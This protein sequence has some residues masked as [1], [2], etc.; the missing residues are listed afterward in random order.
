[1]TAEQEKR[2]KELKRELECWREEVLALNSVLAWEKHWY[3]WLLIGISTTLFTFLW[4]LDMSVLSTVAVACLVVT[5][6]DYLGPIARTSICARDSWSGAKERQ[7]EDVCRALARTEHQV[8]SC[9][10]SRQSIKAAWPHLYVVVEVIGLA[11]LA[12]IGYTVNNMFLSYLLVTTALM[13]PGLKHSGF[14]C[15]LSSDVKT[16]FSSSIKMKKN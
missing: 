11:C 12:Y 9:W 5:A 14:L 8:L 3:P 13:L 4:Y 16:T 2:V 10:K 15:K 7:L 6:V 1:M